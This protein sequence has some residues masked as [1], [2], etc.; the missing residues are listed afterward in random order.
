MY[1]LHMR[2]L[3]FI[4]LFFIAYPAFAVEKVNTPAVTKGRLQLEQLT[5]TTWD[6]GRAPLDDHYRY[7]WQVSGGI[8]DRFDLALSLTN[9]YGGIDDDRLSGVGVR[10][11]YEFTEQG[12]WWLSSA[13]QARYTHRV[14][15]APS[16]LHVRGILQRKEGPFSTVLNV[17][18]R[19]EI[20]HDR[21]SSF[22]IRSALQGLYSFNRDLAVGA[23]L[24]SVQGQANDVDLPDHELEF[25]PVISG[26]LLRHGKDI[27]TANAGYYWGLTNEAPDGNARFQLNYG[28]QF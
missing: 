18:L 6:D 26:T 25:G 20:G 11:K 27:L 21:T 9:T 17:G 3:G 5:L 24:F 28:I 14:D 8:T 19:R 7:R 15:T 13:I 2:R 4:F 1:F 12:D 23:E 10:G 22:Q 16:D